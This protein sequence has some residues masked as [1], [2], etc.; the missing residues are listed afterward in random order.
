MKRA[1]SRP[2][3]IADLLCS[4]CINRA[5]KEKGNNSAQNDF[6]EEFRLQFFFGV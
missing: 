1:V 2:R 3:L 5:F 6:E 4:L